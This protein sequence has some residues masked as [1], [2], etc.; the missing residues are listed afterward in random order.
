MIMCSGCDFPHNVIQQ[1]GMKMH[2]FYVLFIYYLFIHVLFITIGKTVEGS[3]IQLKETAF[4]R[5]PRAL[6]IECLSNHDFIE[7]NE[8]CIH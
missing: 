1:I 4:Q 2:L 3:P 8:L 7:P 6:L 5:S